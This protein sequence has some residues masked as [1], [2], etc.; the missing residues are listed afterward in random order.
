MKRKRYLI[1]AFFI[2]TLF[3][4]SCGEDT[5]TDIIEKEFCGPCAHTGQWKVYKTDASPCFKTNA[6]CL[7]WA[8]TNGYSDKGCVFCK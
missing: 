8:A 1:I 4:S 7:D 2:I 6:A 5:Y 3:N